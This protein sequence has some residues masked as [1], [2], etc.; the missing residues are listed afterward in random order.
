VTVAVAKYFQIR[1]AC[2][3]AGGVL[4]DMAMAMDDAVVTGLPLQQL[5]GC[6]GRW[7]VEARQERV[8][9]LAAS[10]CGLTGNCS[11]R[12]RALHADLVDYAESG[13]LRDKLMGNAGGT[14]SDL[15]QILSDSKG[16]VPSIR[17]LRRRFSGK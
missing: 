15:Y 7:R 11:M 6:V 9:R 2:A 16:K 14:A 10:G 3:A 17:T 8:R 12:A 5:V 4:T 1:D 13:Y